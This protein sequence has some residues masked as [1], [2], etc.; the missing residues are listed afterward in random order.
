MFAAIVSV[1]SIAVIAIR[2][3]EA[4]HEQSD[5]EDEALHELFR[6]NDKDHT[7]LR[8]CMQQ[9]ASLGLLFIRAMARRKSWG[10][11]QKCKLG[12]MQSSSARVNKHW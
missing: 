10:Q 6:A 9:G 8:R 3:S 2:I 7:P 11:S 5:A 4:R 12:S 1:V